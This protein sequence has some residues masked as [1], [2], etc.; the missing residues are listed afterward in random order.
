[1]HFVGTWDLLEIPADLLRRGASSSSNHLFLNCDFRDT[2]TL[3]NPS[4][5]RK[6]GFHLISL[7]KS[8]GGHGGKCRLQALT[9][10]QLFAAAPTLVD[11]SLSSVVSLG[12][13][14]R[15]CNMYI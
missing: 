3:Q 14:R 9:P 13:W 8:D 6:L 10:L 12:N 15:A 11:L 5:C 4:I 2:A 7:L 1:M